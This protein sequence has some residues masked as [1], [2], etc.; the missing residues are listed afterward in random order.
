MTAIRTPLPVSP[1]NFQV[2]SACTRLAVLALVA[3]LG[4]I[5]DTL[6]TSDRDASA[7]TPAASV[8]T[9]KPGIR[10]VVVYSLT[11]FASALRAELNARSAVPLI[12]A[13]WLSTF[14]GTER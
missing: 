1:L 14:P 8:F 11:A 5:R 7:L 12:A 4:M 2:F 9:A 13:R 10:F 3:V 6:T